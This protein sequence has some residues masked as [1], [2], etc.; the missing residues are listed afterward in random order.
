M[1]KQ[2]LLLTGVSI[3]LAACATTA[4]ERVDDRV[5]Q[6]LDGLEKTGETRSCLSPARIQSIDAATERKF[7]V[8]TGV[9]DYWVVNTSG[10]CSGATRSQNRLQYTLP[11]GQLCKGEIIKIVDNQSG[12]QAGSCG[13][14]K[15]ERLQPKVTE[16]DQE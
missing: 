6:K 2:T 5:V 13:W 9:N 3:L 12:F 10:R 8:E 14:G 11:T 1:I 15:F 4:T 7:L 16:E